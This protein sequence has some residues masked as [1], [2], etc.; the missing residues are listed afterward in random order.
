MTQ[1]DF[2]EI[3]P[4]ALKE[5]DQHLRATTSHPLQMEARPLPKSGRRHPAPG[6]EVTWY[7]QSNPD[8]LFKF[9]PLAVVV[10]AMTK[11]Y[12]GPGRSGKN[13]GVAIGLRRSFVRQVEAATVQEPGFSRPVRKKLLAACGLSLQYLEPRAA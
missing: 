4:G 6:E 2:W 9:D 3:L 7:I 5:L 8:A 13:R 1:K 11:K 10:W 12:A